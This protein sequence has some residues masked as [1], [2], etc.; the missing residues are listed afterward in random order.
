MGRDGLR[1]E[2]RRRKRNMVE[3][4]EEKSGWKERVEDGSSK[5]RQYIEVK[6]VK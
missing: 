5:E 3:Y 6:P 2:E 4:G 1:L